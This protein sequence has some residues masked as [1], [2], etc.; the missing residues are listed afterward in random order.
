LDICLNINEL[1]VY[2]GIIAVVTLL[3]LIVL[4]K[5]FVKK[6]KKEFDSIT[7]DIPEPIGED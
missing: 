5:I 1:A 4:D 6:T 2:S 3:G 7:E